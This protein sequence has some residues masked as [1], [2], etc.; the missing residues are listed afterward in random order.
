[1]LLLSFCY[2]AWL[3]GASGPLSRMEDHAGIGRMRFATGLI[4]LSLASVILLLVARLT[5]GPA[6]DAF[7]ILL[8]GVLGYLAASSVAA[9]LRAAGH[10]FAMAMTCLALPGILP[11][12]AILRNSRPDIMARR[13]ILDGRIGLIPFF[14]A[15][16][17]SAGMLASLA[18]PVL[19]VVMA[20]AIVKGIREG[21]GTASHV[22]HTVTLK[23][24]E[25]TEEMAAEPGLLADACR[26]LRVPIEQGLVFRLEDQ[27]GFGP[28]V[29]V[30]AQ[31]CKPEGSSYFRG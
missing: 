4:F 17:I 12:L 10:G 5:P 23:V 16:S 24:D 28:T 25:L 26:S 14:F 29:V 11:V 3:V 21:G 7:V 1:M 30:D 15:L 6:G 2:M 31:R 8:F 22:G 19:R 9:R 27:A 20:E 18:T 13:G